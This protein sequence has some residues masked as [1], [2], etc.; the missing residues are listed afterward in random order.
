MTSLPRGWERALD[1]IGHGLAAEDPGLG[2]RFAFFTMLTRHEA[3]P[4]TEQVPGRRQRFLRRA[5]LL[6]LI[7]IS[8]AA[9]LTVSWLTPSRQASPACPIA[10]ARDWPSLSHATHCQRGP[11]IRRDTMPVH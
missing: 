1:Q 5:A 6:P 4:S 7:A 11:A 8:L 9:L 2:M 10:A 3:M